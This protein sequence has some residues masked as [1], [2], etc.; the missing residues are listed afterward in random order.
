MKHETTID[1]LLDLFEQTTNMSPKKQ[2]QL[3]Q[4]EWL[5]CIYLKLKGKKQET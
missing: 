4:I 3:L 1:N 2:L 5:L